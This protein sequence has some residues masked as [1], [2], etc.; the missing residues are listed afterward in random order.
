MKFHLDEQLHLDGYEVSLLS[1]NGNI[2]IGTFEFSNVLMS[3]S[4]L[5]LAL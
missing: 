4:A 1:L 5:L 2:R 3:R